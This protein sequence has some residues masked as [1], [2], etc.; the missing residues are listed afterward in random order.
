MVEIVI[1]PVVVDDRSGQ[2]PPPPAR[3]KGRVWLGDAF[4]RFSHFAG[5][6][7]PIFRIPST[8]MTGPSLKLGFVCKFCNFLWEGKFE[9]SYSPGDEASGHS[10]RL[11]RQL[12]DFRP[13]PSW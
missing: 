6:Q 3:G 13:A 4:Q 9:Q 2:T 1:S 11:Q 5:S 12:D 7:K 10:F 8:G